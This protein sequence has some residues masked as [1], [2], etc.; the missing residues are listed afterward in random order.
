M[1]KQKNK[2]LNIGVGPEIF[3]INKDTDLLECLRRL[4]RTGCHVLVCIEGGRISGVVSEGD[5][6]RGLLNN[7]SLEQKVGPLVN[8]N[9]V[10]GSGCW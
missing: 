3:I 1:T 4:D 9:P 6:R 7:M 2:A 10:R 8:E 5:I